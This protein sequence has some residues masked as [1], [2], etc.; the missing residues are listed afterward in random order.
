MV[1]FEGTQESFVGKN[2]IIDFEEFAVGK[3]GV[4][5]MEVSKKLFSVAGGNQ[6]NIFFFVES[7]IE[8]GIACHGDIFGG[9]IVFGFK[10]IVFFKVG[11]TE[12]MRDVVFE[13]IVKLRGISRYKEVFDG[14]YLCIEQVTQKEGIIV[15]KAE[16]GVY[17]AVRGKQDIGG[18][19]NGDGFF[20]TVFDN[21]LIAGIDKK[22]IFG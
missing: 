22:M 13:A 11:G 6:D 8:N 7:G 10:K 15:V 9:V 18:K 21:I 4:V 17:I 12:I 1:F 5:G 3:L 14:E 2:G 20:G 16:R 19:D